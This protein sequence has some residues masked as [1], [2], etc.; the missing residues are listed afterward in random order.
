MA[1]YGPPVE[2]PLPKDIQGAKFCPRPY[3]LISSYLWSNSKKKKNC[4]HSYNVLAKSHFEPPFAAYVKVHLRFGLWNW[5]VRGWGFYESLPC[6]SHLSYGCPWS[7]FC[8]PIPTL[9]LTGTRPR[10]S[11]EKCPPNA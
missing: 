7:L 3:H 4:T 11:I 5:C 6:G 2:P 9:D 1:Q 10:I 8:T